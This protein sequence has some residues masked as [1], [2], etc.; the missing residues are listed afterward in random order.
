MAPQKPQVQLLQEAAQT[1]DNDDDLSALMGSAL[2]SMANKVLDVGKQMKDAVED[3]VEDVQDL[4]ETTTRSWMF[5]RRNNQDSAPAIDQRRNSE[6][7]NAR[8]EENDESSLKEAL[9]ILQSEVDIDML[10]E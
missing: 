10:I 1:E 9:Y 6:E 8:N 5:W 7:E 4:T 2:M 3:V